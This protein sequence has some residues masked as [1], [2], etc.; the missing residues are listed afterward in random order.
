MNTPLQIHP[1]YRPD[2]DGLRA[3]A[4]LSVVVFHAFPTALPGGFIGVDVFFVISGYLIS[5]ILFEQLERGTFTFTDFYI[6]RVKRIFPALLLVLA[7]TTVCGWFLLFQSEYQQLGKHLASGAGFISN[8]ALWSEAGYFD[9]SADLKPLLHLWSLGIEEQFYIFWPPIL[10]V[11]WTW[12]RHLPKILLFLGALSLGISLMHTKTNEVAAFYSPLSRGWELL[13]GALLAWM[14]QRPTRHKT[15]PKQANILSGAGLVLL[16]YGFFHINK[17]VGF[18]GLW[19]VLP[20]LGAAFILAAGP[21]AWFNQTVL[22]HRSMVWFGLISFPLYL[23]HWPLLSFPHI[24]ES[25]HT[26]NAARVGAIALSVLL[27]WLTYKFVETPMRWGKNGQRNVAILAV[28]WLFAI[29]T[30]AAIY[31][32][33]GVPSR[34][35]VQGYNN[36]SNELLRLPDTDAGCFEYIG[37]H[38]PLFPYCRFSDSRS[39][40]TVAV[41]GD[42]HAHVAYPGIAE[43]LKSFRI[44][45]VLLATSGCPPLKDQPIEKSD[46]ERTLCS[47]RIDELLKTLQKKT[48]IRKVFLFT[49]GPI[50][51]EGTEPLTGL[52]MHL[53]PIS[54][55]LYGRG[56]QRTIDFLKAANKQVYYIIEN[57]ELA[58][59][60]SA[61]LPRPLRISAHDCQVPK[62]AVLARQHDY[63]QMLKGL[64][65]VTILDTI[66]IFCPE[67][68]CI[69]TDSENRLLYADDDH[70]SVSGSRFQVQ[71]LLK[72]YLHP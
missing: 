53:E 35:S 56:L 20:T 72:E 70:L 14:H 69:V 34:S 64:T 7:G 40:T 39:E 32:N 19:P 28:L 44:N 13:I 36:N 65:G 24:I 2:I 10:L 1:K 9:S 25:G 63:R 22:S 55:E 67:E 45:T 66:P 41:V 26:S 4:V 71:Q 31:L 23:W 59:L 29:A 3:V 30:G 15:S 58:R 5:G 42:S 68:K 11:S 37:N 38:K 49:R 17:D 61:C 6:R 21:S 46:L 47:T 8:F 33:D 60:P 62:E 27:A 16:L 57:P 18:P 51:L 54:A 50:Y 52:T 48:D 12:K 43:L